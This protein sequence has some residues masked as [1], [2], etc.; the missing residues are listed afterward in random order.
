ME[1]FSVTEGYW[2]PEPGRVHEFA[3]AT[4][5]WSLEE[6]MAR[7]LIRQLEA[8][9]GAL[10]RAPHPDLNEQRTQIAETLYLLANARQSRSFCEEM[11]IA[12]WEGAGGENTTAEGAASEPEVVGITNGPRGAKVRALETVLDRLGVKTPRDAKA[13]RSQI[14]SGME[15][16]GYPISTKALS[17]ML[18]RKGLTNERQL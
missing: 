17:S 6:S 4:A 10:E 18:S 14:L 15:A 12:S 8:K 3:T 5:M 16:A 2:M 9:L 11:A 1:K 7:E 13:K